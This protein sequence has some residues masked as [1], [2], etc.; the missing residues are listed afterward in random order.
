MLKEEIDQIAVEGVDPNVVQLELGLLKLSAVDIAL[1]RYEDLRVLHG[2]KLDEVQRRYIA[3][4]RER[5]E[6]IGS[7][8][9]EAFL[10]ICEARLAAYNK[11]FDAWLEA[12]NNGRGH[13]QSFAIGE[14]F[15]NF[16]GVPKP[17]PVSAS[18]IDHKFRTILVSVNEKLRRCKLT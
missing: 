11:A 13:E 10:Q 1:F 9:E 17:N 16:C 14:I 8:A 7:L 12:H 6:T 4:L 5:G 15:F 3:H 2:P 18:L